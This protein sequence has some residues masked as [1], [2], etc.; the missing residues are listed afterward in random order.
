[1][2]FGRG[3]LDLAAL[4]MLAGVL[5]VFEHPATADSHSGPYQIAAV[6]NV[7]LDSLRSSLRETDA[8]GFVTKLSL[9]H[10]LDTLLENFVDYHR[11]QGDQTL[12]SLHQQFGELLDSTLSE[13][14]DKDPQLYRKLGNARGQLWLILRDPVRFQAAVSSAAKSQATLRQ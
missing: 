12:P 7:N 14:R 4:V 9:K 2:K 13:L 3:L 5:I 1:M 11:G 8:I 10:Q 6:E